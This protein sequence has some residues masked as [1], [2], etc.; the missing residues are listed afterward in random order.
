MSIARM[1]VLAAVLFASTAHAAIFRGQAATLWYEVRGSGS[2]TPLMVVNG[3][4]GVEHGYLLVSDAW[5]VLARQRRVVFYDQR[6]VGRS[7]PLTPRQ[8]CTLADQIEDLEALRR[9]LGYAHMD[10]L[11]HSWGGYLAMAYAARHPDHVEHLVICDSAAPRWE[12]TVFLFKNIFPDVIAHQ[13]QSAFAEALGDSAAA[14]RNFRDYLSM[15]CYSPARREAML[16]RPAPGLS[17]AINQRLNDDLKRY[18]LTPELPKFTFPTLVL[19]GR[20]DINV[21]PSVAWGIH[22]AIPNSIFHV[23][24]TSGHLPFY[25]Q[26]EEFV[27]VLETFF[28]AS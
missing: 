12:D 27:Q 18:D 14:A 13:D 22:R 21:A 6:G 19:T 23:F 5:D 15:L 3:G 24:E 11:G 4:P 17:S 20:Y 25:E 9:H 7:A 26:P 8:S 1:L 10:V 28:G 16:K 2:G